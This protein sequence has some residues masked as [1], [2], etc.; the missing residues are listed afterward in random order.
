MHPVVIFANAGDCDEAIHKALE[1]WRVR[2]DWYAI[3]MQE[4]CHEICRALAK[5][6]AAHREMLQA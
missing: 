6:D 3:S 5:L 4:A 2:G 1:Q